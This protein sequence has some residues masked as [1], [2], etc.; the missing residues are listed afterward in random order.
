MSKPG[1]ITQP[2]YIIFFRGAKKLPWG[3][4]PR[5]HSAMKPHPVRLEPQSYPHR[6]DV[7]ARFADVDP[8]RHLNNVRI[9]EFYQE[10]SISF[11]RALAK[12]LHQ[13]RQ[14]EHRILVA[15]QTMDYLAELAW[16]G[17]ITVGVGVS[18]AGGASF[19]LG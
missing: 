16:P 7:H 4:I 17:L 14:P 8:Q 10:G 18:R 2:R 11:N 6:L 12:E 9:A 5:S 1:I 3:N 15:R 13:E 19:V